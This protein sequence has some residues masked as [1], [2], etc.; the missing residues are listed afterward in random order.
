M[1]LH[2]TN[3]RMRET[4]KTA[5]SNSTLS[6]CIGM[7][8]H[9]SSTFLLEFLIL[10]NNSTMIH[11][12]ITAHFH[13][14]LPTLFCRAYQVQI[15]LISPECTLSYLWPNVDTSGFYYFLPE[16]LQQLHFG[17]PYFQISPCEIY[18][19]CFYNRD[20][21]EKKKQNKTLNILYLF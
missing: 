14:S 13:V 11:L 18:A 17:S 10:V 8:K 19:K 21:K 7:D 9:S 12:V 3:T 5:C 20:L 16:Q 15:V 2:Y 4:D 6:F 1:E